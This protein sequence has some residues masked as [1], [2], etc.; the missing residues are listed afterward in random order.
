[1]VGAKNA[2]IVPLWTQHCHCGSESLYHTYHLTVHI[3]TLSTLTALLVWYVRQNDCAYVDVHETGREKVRKD[4]VRGT[5]HD[6]IRSMQHWM[7][8]DWG[9]NT[10]T[11]RWH[12]PSS[13]SDRHWLESAAVKS[14][15][16][17]WIT[18]TFSNDNIC[19]TE[20]TSSPV[21]GV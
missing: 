5:A 7:S 10:D 1:M 13:L 8:S 2:K 15:T 12:F 21:Q 16:L 20:R 19:E 9:Y 4:N 3:S 14:I 6:V 18:L 17:Q 11:E